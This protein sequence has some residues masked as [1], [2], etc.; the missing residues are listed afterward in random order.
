[1]S[2]NTL[3]NFA[4]GAIFRDKLKEFES[5]IVI[6]YVLYFDDFQINNALG[7]HTYSI[8][9]CYIHFP[10][11]PKHLLSQLQF[12]FPAAFISTSN[13]KEYGNE[14]SFHPLVEELKQ[15]ELGIEIVLG[16]SV[17]KVHFILGLIVGDNLAVNSVLGYV[18]SFTAKRYCR[19]CRPIRSEMQY[20]CGEILKKP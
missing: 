13:L 1:M 4:N 18:Q 19:A 9:G 20:D 2:E 3:S 8:C 14:R 16:S 6:P 12:I 17:R 5:A 10:I 11:I 15:L 7:S